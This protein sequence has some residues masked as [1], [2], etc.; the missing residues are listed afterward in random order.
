MSFQLKA[1][2]YDWRYLLKLPFECQPFCTIFVVFQ[3]VVG[4]VV[5]VLWIFVEA[6][7]IDTALTVARGDMQRSAAYPWLICM[8]LIIVW[9]RMGYSLGRI[10]TRKLEVESEAQLTEEAVKKRSRLHFSLIE[11]KEAWELVSRVSGL[12]LVYKCGQKKLN[13]LSIGK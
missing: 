2:K 7:F 4:S 8:V 9:K 12:V 13:N 6:K 1:Q 11:D 5:T 3:K 10:A